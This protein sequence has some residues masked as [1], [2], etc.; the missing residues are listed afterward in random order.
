MIFT[1]E[2]LAKLAFVEHNDK[3]EVVE[4]DHRNNEVH[5]TEDGPAGCGI[6]EMHDGSV[7]TLLINETGKAMIFGGDIDTIKVQGEC[8]LS[9]SRPSYIHSIEMYDRARICINRHAIGVLMD[10]HT[11]IAIEPGATIMFEGTFNRFQKG[12]NARDFLTKLLERG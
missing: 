9:L 12:D 4:C 11:A 8:L 3:R 1:I 7:K 5:V 2:Y 10:I 6:F